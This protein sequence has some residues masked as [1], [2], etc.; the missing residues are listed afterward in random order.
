M[1][2]AKNQGKF[3]TSHQIDISKATKDASGVPQAHPGPPSL[4]QGGTPGLFTRTPLQTLWT[5][6]SNKTFSKNL[7]DQP[8]PR[9]KTCTIGTLRV[10][11]NNV[12]QP[13]GPLLPGEQARMTAR[14]K[15]PGQT[16]LGKIQTESKVTNKNESNLVHTPPGTPP[17]H[18]HSKGQPRDIPLTGEGDRSMTGSR[19]FR[20]A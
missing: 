13:Q 17:V 15:Y 5:L 7:N 6:N 4:K 16:P 2:V 9:A 18:H 20:T 1:H 19:Y 8:P 12:G 11:Q 14:C 3:A 10:H